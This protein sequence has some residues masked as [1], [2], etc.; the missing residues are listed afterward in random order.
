VREEF[1]HYDVAQQMAAEETQPSM[2]RPVLP[3]DQRAR[4]ARIGGPFAGRVGEALDL[5]LE[6][7][8][9][10]ALLDALDPPATARPMS[11]ERKS[12]RDLASAQG[13]TRSINWDDVELIPQPTDQTCWAAAAA[14][15]IGWRDQLSLSP[16]TV[17][18]ICSRSTIAGLSPFDRETFASQIGLQT[19]SPK[20]YSVE[21]FYDLLAN[22]GP[23]WVSKIAGGG[24][25]SGHAVVVTGMYSDG[26]Q[27]YVRIADPWDRVVGAPGAPGGY[28]STHGTGSRYIM[29]YEDFHSEYELR[30]VGDPPTPQILHSGGTAGRV[31]NTGTAAAPRGYAMAARDRRAATPARARALVDAGTIATIAGT[32][33]TLL[34]E[35]GGDIAWQLP[36]WS[37]HKHPN[38]VAP[39]TEAPYLPGVISLA[40]WPSAGGTSAN[41][42]IR[43]YYNGTSIGPVYVERGRTNDTVGWGLLVTGMIEDDPRLYSRSP[44]GVANGPERVPALHVVLTYEFHA[45]PLTDDPNASRRITLYADGTHEIDNEWIQRSGEGVLDKL[46]QP[47]PQDVARTNVAVAVE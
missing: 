14:M 29:R 20:S 8:S 34:T 45:P 44:L 18:S 6:P 25:T 22:R 16:E 33:V 41:C 27:H 19:E 5:G 28:A 1:G 3:N 12:R 9:V 4:A 21:G 40:G 26:D 13:A 37:G 7:K 39:A 30:I 11:A 42:A 24:A 47:E 36:H 43:W 17:A 2:V 23:L 38:D 32:A 46:S 10:D 35:S 15:V 31:P